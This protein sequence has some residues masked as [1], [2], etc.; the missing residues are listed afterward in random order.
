MA[1]FV[2]ISLYDECALGV[3][4][5]SA[6][7]K[8]AG[9]RTRLVF[10]KQVIHNRDPKNLIVDAGYSG[11]TAACS[12]HEYALVRDLV[13]AYEADFIGLSL[14]SQCF[15][16]AVWLSARLKRDFPNA[17]LLWGGVDPTLHP[18]LGIEHCDF[19]AIGEAELSLPELIDAIQ[20]GRDPGG[21]AGFWMRNGR[22]IRRNPARPLVQDLD[23]LPFPDFERGEKFL[24][25][26]NAVRAIQESFYI[27]TT[28]RGCPY[29]CTYCA[30]ASL[31][32]LYP[33]QRFLR[34]RSVENVL[35]E[36]AWVRGIYPEIDYIAFYD[37]IFTLNKKWLRAFAPRYRDEVGLPFW[38]YTY[39]GHL[40]DEVAALLKEMGVEHVQTGVQSGSERVLREIYRRADPGGVLETARLLKR[41]GIP[42]RYD[43]IAGNPMET[44]EDR[45]ATLEVLLAVPHPFR[46]NPA[47]PLC[48]FF[49]SPIARMALERGIPLKQVEGV[50]G[51]HPAVETHYRF[52]KA[53]Y[54]LTQYPVVER[55]FIRSLARNESL[56]A[57][58]E[59]LEAFQGALEATYWTGPGGFAPSKECTLFCE[60]LIRE[61]TAERDRLRS[62][63]AAIEGKRLY[64]LYRKVREFLPKRLG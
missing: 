12:E 36:I 46:I 55:D 15:G 14:A 26:D 11:P 43:L 18:D 25:Q 45:L 28:Q 19:L 10:L 48:L 24:V 63:L 59:I 1:N 33:G 52:W 58:P 50:N 3:R 21:V 13:G 30:N 31:P 39:P 32:E 53:I 34:R 7:L 37:D 29:R 60:G 23:Q 22:T 47:N 62:R 41:H 8:Q 40:D 64:R 5:L 44:D 56:K 61:L 54:D 9:H 42:V 6:V 17:P 57:N 35:A 2:F 20:A 38:C 27:L 49:N 16:L 51:Y 4:Y